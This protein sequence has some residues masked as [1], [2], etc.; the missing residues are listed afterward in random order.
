MIG[1]LDELKISLTNSK[2]MVSIWKQLFEPKQ[3]GS[4][5]EI[6]RPKCALFDTFSISSCGVYNHSGLKI[7]AA[8]DLPSRSAPRLA[9]LRVEEEHHQIVFAARNS[10]EKSETPSDAY[11]EEETHKKNADSSVWLGAVLSWFLSYLPRSI[12]DKHL[13]NSR[14]YVTKVYFRNDKF[15]K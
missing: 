8:R 7:T 1:K 9:F 2:P 12:Y 11:M 4:F 10:Q 5:I 15:R 6:T 13:L 14:Y 3:K